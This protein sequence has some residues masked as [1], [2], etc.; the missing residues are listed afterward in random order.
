M[1]GHAGDAI[2]ETG[3]FVQTL[4]LKGWPVLGALHIISVFPARMTH[5]LAMRQDFG[6][7]IAPM[8]HTYSAAT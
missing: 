8:G 7:S 2:D 1:T 3:D 5:G 6:V 4:E